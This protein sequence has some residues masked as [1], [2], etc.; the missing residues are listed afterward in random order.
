M[1]IEP[2]TAS[3]FPSGEKATA[4][5]EPFPSRATA[6][7]SLDKPKNT[8]PVRIKVMPVTKNDVIPP[9][10]LIELKEINSETESSLLKKSQLFCYYIVYDNVKTRRIQLL[11]KLDKYLDSTNT[12]YRANGDSIFVVINPDSNSMIQ[13]TI[14]L[15]L[16]AVAL[17]TSVA[18]LVLGILQAITAETGVTLLGI[19]LFAL[20]LYALQGTK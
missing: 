18:V 13:G 11:E 14:N 19:G 3:I 17:G 20:A 1:P 5:T 4:S 9:N 7:R 6:Q 8:V 2:A 12:V 16:K 10:V 15:I